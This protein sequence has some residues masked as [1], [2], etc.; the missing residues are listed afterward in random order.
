MEHKPTNLNF[1]LEKKKTT[2]ESLF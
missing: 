1:L 2:I